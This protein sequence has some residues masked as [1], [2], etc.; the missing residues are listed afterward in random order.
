[1][2]RTTLL[3]TP[4]L[5]P[6][7]LKPPKTSVIG[8]LKS[9]VFSTEQQISENLTFMAENLHMTWFQIKGGSLVQ[10]VAKLITTFSA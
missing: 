3:N 10:G 2:L 8:P 7:P 1:M 5:V 6:G 9:P 4:Y